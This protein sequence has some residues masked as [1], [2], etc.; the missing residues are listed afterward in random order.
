[1]Y[2]GIDVGGT[3]T[4]GARLN[5]SFAIET[6]AKI[7]TRPGDVLGSFRDILTPLLAGINLA[8]VRRLV[9][10]STL[11]LN[12]ILTGQAEAVGVLATGGPG[13][14]AE[15]FGKGPLYAPLTGQQD[16]RGEVLQTQDKTEAWAAVERLLAAGAEAFA[17][18]SKFGPKNPELENILAAAVRLKA[19]N[20]PL[21]EASRLSGRLNFPRRLNT[22]I[23]NSSVTRLYEDFISNLEAA[24]HDFGLT[25]PLRLLTADGGALTLEDARLKPVQVL[26]AGPAAGLLGLWSLASLTD[27]ALMVDIGGTSTDLAVI[28][29][30]EPLLTTEGLEINGYPTLVRAFLTQSIALGGDLGLVSHQGRVEFIERR[31]GPALALCPKEVGR[32]PPTFTD[33]LN[34]LGLT[35]VGQIEVSQEALAALA[36]ERPALKTAAATLETALAII[37]TAT[38]NLLN[39]VNNR[40]VYTLNEIRLTRPVTPKVVAFLGGPAAALAKPVAETLGLTALTPPEAAVA[41]AIGAARSRPCLAANLYADTALGTLTVPTLGFKKTIGRDYNVSQAKA[42][43]IAVLTE[44]LTRLPEAGPPQITEVETFNQLTSYG[45]ADKIIRLRAQSRAGLLGTAL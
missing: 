26:A 16:H 20:R 42:E 1:M 39:Q 5:D 23:F 38:G 21:T 22:A 36:P 17:V 11:G 30:G 18:I 45:Q 41:N 33:A 15:Y 43:L 31:E 24:A 19:S 35:A 13:L 14:G 7:P 3:H 9:I 40:P 6:T 4:D 34:V 27:D 28:A 12:A 10:S 44:A 8:K 25:C 2:L 32:R 29:D 37:R